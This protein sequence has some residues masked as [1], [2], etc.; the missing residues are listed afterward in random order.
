MGPEDGDLVVTTDLDSTISASA[1]GGSKGGFPVT[2]T[3]SSLQ[4]GTDPAGIFAKFTDTVS[5]EGIYVL[6]DVSGD[7]QETHVVLCAPALDVSTFNASAAPLIF[8][9]GPESDSVAA[10][11]WSSVDSGAL[12]CPPQPCVPTL[13]N[14]SDVP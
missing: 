4:L 5:S 12:L 6:P 13:C 1:T 3:S 9:Q 8:G 2:F 11:A 14:C 10:A 7:S